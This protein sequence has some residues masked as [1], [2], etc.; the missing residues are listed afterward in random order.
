MKGVIDP[1]SKLLTIDEGTQPISLMQHAG[2]Y[3]IS[4]GLSSTQS[5]IST[6][7]V[8]GYDPLIWTRIIFST[9]KVDSANYFAMQMEQP[10]SLPLEFIEFDFPEF[11]PWTF[12]P[13]TNYVVSF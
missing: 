10:P 9:W 1:G 8:T 5:T 2:N 7:F 4:D 3:I 13:G 6:D 12:A 11:A